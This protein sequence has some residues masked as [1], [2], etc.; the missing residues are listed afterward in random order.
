MR[1]KIGIVDDHPSVIVGTAAIINS[2]PDMSVVSVAD[3]VKGLIRDRTDFDIVLLD[4]RLADG[5]TPTQ[6]VSALLDVKA[7]VLAYTSGESADLVR[8]ATK[9]GVSGMIRKSESPGRILAAVRAA[10]EGKTVATPDWAAALCE[11]QSFVDA[12]LT[13]RES[14]VL[15]RYASGQT[16]EQVANALFVSIDTVHDH[17]RRIRRRY[18]AVGRPARTKVDL[19]RRAVEDG[20]VAP[21]SS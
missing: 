19:H 13:R 1:A 3:T 14:E 6:N 10:L 4:L 20:L 15:Q 5:S 8:E 17:L 2:Q 7:E 11:D 18:A 21:T 9:A 16:A 12:N